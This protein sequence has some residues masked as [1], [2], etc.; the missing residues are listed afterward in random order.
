MVC[1]GRDAILLRAGRD[2]GVFIIPD[3]RAAISCNGSHEDV[4]PSD[5]VLR[6]LST[7]KTI[8]AK[9]GADG[10]LQ[11]ERARVET[12]RTSIHSKRL[13]NAEN[14]IP[15]AASVTAS[16]HTWSI[17]AVCSSLSQA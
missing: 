17:C 2:K 16:P 12:R 15:R 4:L 6:W 7:R 13:V 3:S 1:A 11:V 10:V 9:K 8:K 5:E 14:L